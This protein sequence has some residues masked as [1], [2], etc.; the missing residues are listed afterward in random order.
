MIKREKNNHIHV[1]NYVNRTSQ[2]STYS[3]AQRIAIAIKIAGWNRVCNTKQCYARQR[4][5]EQ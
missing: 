3:T 2:H 4:N 1:H 5:A